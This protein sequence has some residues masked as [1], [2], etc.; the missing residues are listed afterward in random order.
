MAGETEL[1]QLVGRIID[2]AKLLVQVDDPRAIDLH[3]KA[4][5]RSI[6]LEALDKN[7][8]SRPKSAKPEAEELKPY[9]GTGPTSKAPSSSIQVKL[10]DLC[11]VTDHLDFSD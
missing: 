4:W 9:R 1:K 7:Y 5:G 3:R 8:W 6:P 2:L 11:R 10:I